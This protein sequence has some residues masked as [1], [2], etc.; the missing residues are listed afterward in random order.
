MRVKMLQDMRIHDN[1]VFLHTRSPYH[2]CTKH[3]ATTNHLTIMSSKISRLFTC[4]TAT[5]CPRD[6]PLISQDVHSP[7]PHVIWNSLPT[8]VILCDSEHSFKTS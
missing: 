3:W 8:E 4:I 1:K 2:A 7:T 6:W 5:V